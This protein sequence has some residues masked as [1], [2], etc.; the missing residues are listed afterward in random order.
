MLTLSSLLT[1]AALNSPEMCTI[2]IGDKKGGLDFE[3]IKGLPHIPNNKLCV[4]DKEIEGAISAVHTELTKRF[5]TQD[6][7]GM[8]KHIVLVIDEFHQFAENKKMVEKLKDI[9]AMGRAWGIHLIAITQRPDHKSMDTTLRSNLVAEFA[10]RMTRKGSRGLESG[11]DGELQSKLPGKGLFLARAATS[12]N[13]RVQGFWINDIGV[14]VDA[15]QT[16]YKNHQPHFYL[17]EYDDTSNEPTDDTDASDSA[18]PSNLTQW[19]PL[20]DKAKVAV[21]EGET[22]NATWFRN[23]APSVMKKQI[24]PNTA[25]KLVGLLIS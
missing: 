11:V 22:V 25:K 20:V 18:L 5:T 24:N 6:R 16:E 10:G 7:V 12:D 17:P 19:Q 2:I 23:Q 1:L 8:H 4:T 9:T 13:K 3:P 21:N 15:I 14:W